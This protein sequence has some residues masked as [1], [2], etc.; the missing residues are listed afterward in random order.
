MKRKL[1]KIKTKNPDFYHQIPKYQKMMLEYKEFLKQKMQKIR[2]AKKIQNNKIN[3][4]LKKSKFT[5]KLSWRLIKRNGNKTKNNIPPLN[6]KKEIIINPKEK[7][8]ILHTTLANTLPPDLENKHI[9]FHK[10]ITNKINAKSKNNEK[11]QIPHNDILNSPIL[12]YEIQNCTNDLQNDEAYGPNLI[13]KLMI[14]KGDVPLINK[15]Q[16]LFNDCLI[17]GKFPRIWNF[18]NIHLIPKPGKR[19]SDP[20][21]YRPIAVSS[22]LGRFFERI[23]SKRLQQYCVK[24]QTFKNNQCGFQMNRCTDDMLSIFLTDGYTAIQN[25]TDLD[26][27]FTDF[28]KALRRVNL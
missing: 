2:I 28:S 6:Y 18:A 10:Q 12:Q 4:C 16:I 23:L 21:N 7:A 24:N 22:C 9:K 14:K 20:K 3:E 27:V 25:N 26:C 5:D 13:H 15:L 8:E 1:H 17:N 11:V 19:H